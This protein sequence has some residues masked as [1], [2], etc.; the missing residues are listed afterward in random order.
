MEM[1]YN[2]QDHMEWTFHDAKIF[3]EEHKLAESHTFNTN[4]LTEGKKS[5]SNWY[6]KEEVKVIWLSLLTDGIT[7]WCLMTTK[8][9]SKSALS[10]EKLRSQGHA[11]PC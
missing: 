10:R 5:L 7:T 8:A 9:E 6:F 3:Y 4:F 1:G 11:E 2:A